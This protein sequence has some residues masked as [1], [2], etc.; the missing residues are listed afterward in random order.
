MTSRL[1]LRRFTPEDLDDLAALHA[2][3]LVMRY[4]DDGRPV[5]R[6]IVAER[7]LPG[8]LEQ[9]DRL[10]EGLGTFVM[11]ERETGGFAGW[12][13]LAP[14]GS[15][16]LEDFAGLELGYRLLPSVW[17]RGYAAEGARALIRR[18]FEHLGHPGCDQVAATAM[19]VNTGSRRVMEKAG[20]RYRRTFFT[21]WP[22]PIEGAEHGD[23]VYHR[24]RAD[25]LA[26]GRVRHLPP[27]VDVHGE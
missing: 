15:V 21:Q 1:V 24:T 7:T 20:L 27:A 23:V 12:V 9:N 11:H 8:I 26:D 5:T 18:A 25:W 16:G 19:A 14:P 4:I 10:P 13:S 2:D 22:E 3:P 6:E 17:G